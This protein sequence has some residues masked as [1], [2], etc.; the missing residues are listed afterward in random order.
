MR[1]RLL[2]CAVVVALG[3]AGF[4]QKSLQKKLNTVRT[5]K[6]N[7]RRELQKVKKE[8]V[9]VAGDIKWVDNRLDQLESDL[10]KSTDD[11]EGSKQKQARLAVEV[12][13][14][15]KRLEARRAQVGLRLKRGYMKGQSSFLSVL[16]GTQT[17]GDLVSKKV[18]RDAITKRDHEVFED[19][20]ILKAEMILK[21]KQQDSEVARYARLKAAQQSNQSALNDARGEKLDLLQDL[22]GKQDRIKEMIAQFEADERSIASEIATYLKRSRANATS[23]V[24]PNFTGR[25]SRPANGPVTSRFGYRFHPILKINRL[26][27]GVDFGAPSGSPI[28]A[29]A[30]GVVVWAGYKGGFGNTIIIDHGGGIMTLY[31]HSSRLF[32]G[33]G[34]RVKRGDRVAAVGNTGLSTAPHLHFE[35]RVNGKPVDPLGRL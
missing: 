9:I 30:D 26:H 11:L 25:F 13:E 19:F 3:S 5:K 12:I 29:A 24:M 16:V 4:S 27:A 10:E 35:V 20:R 15:G 22:K 31:G 8:S 2:F 18:L 32:V 28:R 34:A 6:D 14:A 21:K 7:L 33:T 23:P 1:A 17:V